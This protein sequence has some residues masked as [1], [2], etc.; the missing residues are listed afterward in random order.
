MADEAA[1]HA[2]FDWEAMSD[3]GEE[4]MGRI[5]CMMICICVCKWCTGL[6]KSS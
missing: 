5:S 3:D 2:D 4:E 1:K 6:M